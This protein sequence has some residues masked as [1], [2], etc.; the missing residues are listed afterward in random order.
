MLSKNHFYCL[1]AGGLVN[2]LVAN[3]KLTYASGTTTLLPGQPAQRPAEIL[4]T[5]THAQL[6]GTIQS[7][8]TMLLC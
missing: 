3:G 1:Q 2:R 6:P 4:G 5:P 8:D 7:I